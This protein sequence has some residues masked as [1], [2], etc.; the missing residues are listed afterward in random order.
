MGELEHRVKKEFILLYSDS[1][2][3]NNYHNRFI[4]NI[5]DN[6]Y[7]IISENGKF[8][9]L[10][11]PENKNLEIPSIPKLG[12]LDIENIIKSKYMIS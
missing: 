1:K 4:Q 9:V 8:Y 10:L 5:V 3:L 2:F 12:D 11:N 7:E 6:N